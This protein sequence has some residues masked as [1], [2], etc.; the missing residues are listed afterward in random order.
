MTEI[1]Q[2][3]IIGLIPDHNYIPPEYTRLIRGA[4][5]LA[6]GD[7]LLDMFADFKGEKKPLSTPLKLWLQE[8]EECRKQGRKIVVLTSGDPNFY[9][10]AKL[11]MREVPPEAVSILPSL[12]T[13]QQAFAHLK[14]SWERSEVVSLHG[15]GSLTVFWSALYRASH[16]HGSGYVAIYTDA[17]NSPSHI[18]KRLLGRGQD[19]WRMHVFEDLGTHDEQVSTWA[20]FDAK[21][22]K[23][24][25]LN[26]VVLENIKRPAPISLGMPECAFVH[27]AGLITKREVRATTLGMLELQPY[28]TLWDLGAGS[29]S[30][31]IEAAA[32]LP[33][34]SI[35]AVEKS[36]LRTEQIAANRAFFG[37]AQVEIIEDEALAAMGHLPDPDR[38][39]IGGGGANL[40]ALIKTAAGK[41]KPGGIIVAN[42]VTLEA[43]KQASSTLESLGMEMSITQLQASRSET[44]GGSLYLK[45]LNQVWLVRGTSASER[46]EE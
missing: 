26:L 37:A 3:H 38:I 36:P 34:G 8:L 32:L 43:L 40:A 16:Y 21:V 35:W 17:E 33:H 20:L 10:L 9:G 6:G 7:R 15:R 42:V 18:A 12:T 23:F 27:E 45:P 11:L 14:V 24:S 22:R 39:F 44:L 41:L 30:V 29:G 25:P 4:D 28:H 1:N 31:S 5:I 19:N 46:E 13:V 2:L